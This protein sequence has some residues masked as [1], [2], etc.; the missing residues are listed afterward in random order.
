M[1]FDITL[2]SRVIEFA[3]SGL[4]MFVWDLTQAF[5]KLQ[6]VAEATALSK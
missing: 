6:I 1:D 5:A 4:G 3:A 2:P